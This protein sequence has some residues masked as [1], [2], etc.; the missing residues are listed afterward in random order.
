MLR[1][2]KVD[3]FRDQM[4]GRMTVATYRWVDDPDERTWDQAV[5]MPA[6]TLAIRA[7]EYGIDPGN[8]E[9]LLDVVMHETFVNYP[10]DQHPLWSAPSI[11]LAREQHLDTIADVRKA[12]AEIGKGWDRSR[13][14]ARSNGYP[15][16]SRHRARMLD[17]IGY[18]PMHRGIVDAARVVARHAW[19]QKQQGQ[20]VPQAMDGREL[21]QIEIAAANIGRRG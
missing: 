13:G 8:T 19:L 7:G 17:H 12:H 10:D 20:D 16:L 4:S 14:Y 3:R 1:H 15:D 21:T 2:F 5:A 18:S 6:E 11:K 9:L